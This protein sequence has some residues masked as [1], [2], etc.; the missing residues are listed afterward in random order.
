MREQ[1]DNIDRD[2][3][4]IKNLKEMLEF[5]STVTKMKNAFGELTSTSR[6]V[7]SRQPRKE[8]VSWKTC[9]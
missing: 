5:K 2:I 8:S 7:T 6:L 9:Q 1:M 4:T 3:E